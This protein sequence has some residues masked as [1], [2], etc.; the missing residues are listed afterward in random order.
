MADLVKAQVPWDATEAKHGETAIVIVWLHN[1]ADVPESLLVLV[2]VIRIIEVKRAHLIWVA[3]TCR[4]IDGGNERYLP[5]RA[6]VINESRALI[7]LKCLKM[8]HRIA[9]FAH[10]GTSRCR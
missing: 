1:L 3:I 8:Q 10:Q 6:Q 9:F 7:N 4:V 2:L 5:T